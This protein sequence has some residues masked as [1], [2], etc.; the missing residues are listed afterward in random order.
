[1]FRFILIIAIV[2][3]GLKVYKAW[4]VYLTGANRSMNGQAAHRIDDIM[5]KDPYCQVYFPRRNGI[6]VMEGGREL[7]FCSRE[8]RDKYMEMRKK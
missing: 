6:R 5:V 7:H 3:L 1:M 2:Y 8:C 4:K